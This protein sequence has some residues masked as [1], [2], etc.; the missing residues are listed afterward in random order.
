MREGINLCASTAVPQ[1]V[2]VHSFSLS[3]KPLSL[4]L[5]LY[6]PQSLRRLLGLP[7]NPVIRRWKFVWASPAA[8]S[9]A[10][11][12]ILK[13]VTAALAGDVSGIFE[14][15]GCQLNGWGHSSYYAGALSIPRQVKQMSFPCLIGC[16]EV[17]LLACQASTKINAIPT[18]CIAL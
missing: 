13:W 17:A 14:L 11:A 5:S 6:I 12:V 3:L 18:A 8:S 15:S 9:G 1:C 10:T 7:L 16:L 2:H 4:H